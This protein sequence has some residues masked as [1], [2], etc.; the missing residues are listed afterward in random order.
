MPFEFD[1]T[2]LHF[3]VYGDRVDVRSEVVVIEFL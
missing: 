2:H 1:S 3:Y